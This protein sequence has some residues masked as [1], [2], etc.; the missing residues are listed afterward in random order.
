MSNTSELLRI[1]IRFFKERRLE[2]LVHADPQSLTHLMYNAQ[3][4]GIIGTVDD[5][6]DGRLRYAALDKELI[7]RH[8]LFFQKLFQ[9]L[10]D[11]F[12]QQHAITT[13]FHT[14]INGIIWFRNVKIVPVAVL[15]GFFLI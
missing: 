6:A 10:T 11:R 13:I 9:P 4:D 1:K 15:I 2:K 5:I 3:F 8:A 14:D 7:L 12:I